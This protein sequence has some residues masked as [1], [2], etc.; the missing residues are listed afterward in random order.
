M[1]MHPIIIYIKNLFGTT[2]RMVGGVK[3]LQLIINNQKFKDL[4]SFLLNILGKA[5]VNYI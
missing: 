3:E 4:T 1:T 5:G 2:D